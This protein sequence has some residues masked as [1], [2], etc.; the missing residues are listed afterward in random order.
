[1]C[2]FHISELQDSDSENLQMEIRSENLDETLEKLRNIFISTPYLRCLDDPEIFALI[3][4]NFELPMKELLD[5]VSLF[6]IKFTSQITFY[7]I[8]IIDQLFKNY[9]NISVVN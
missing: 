7:C 8:Y 4:P 2:T 5:D 1:M 3:D 9:I 6:S